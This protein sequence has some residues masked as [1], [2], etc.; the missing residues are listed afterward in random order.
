M[1]LIDTSSWIE[2][3]RKDGKEEVR[4]RVRKLLLNGEAALCDF[5]LLELWN[6][7][8]GDY[9]KKKLAQMEREIFCVST[10]SAVWT[11]ARELAIRCRKNGI[12]VPPSDLLIAECAESHH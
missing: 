7:A 4:D 1:T 2:A 12:T 6:G 11:L 3:L 5:V 9:E 10:T 8:R